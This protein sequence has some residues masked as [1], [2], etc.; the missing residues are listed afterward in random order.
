MAKHITPRQEEVLKIVKDYIKR[1][2]EAPTLSELQEMLGIKTKRGVVKHLQALERKEYLYRTGE[3]RG[4]VLTDPNRRKMIDLQ[5]L[6][7]ANA[8][9]PLVYA[10]EDTIGSIQVD[11]SIVKSCKDCFALVVSGDSMNMR[12]VNQIPMMDK[13]YVIVKKDFQVSNGDVVLAVIDGSA[14]IKTFKRSENS[15]ILYP[16]SS[17]P[18]HTPIY[19]DPESDS[20]INGK[21]IAV[22]ENPA[23]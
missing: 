22:L 16:E 23:A 13:N 2:S 6:G 10:E 14:T 7:Y 12:K 21:V 15:V 11:K 19:L 4:I 17:N 18:L 9:K 1:F 5:I 20:F 8:G 3:A